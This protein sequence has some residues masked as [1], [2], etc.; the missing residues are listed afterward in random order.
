MHKRVPLLSLFNGLPH[1]SRLG[2]QVSIF[3]RCPSLMLESI[4]LT[5]SNP[6]LEMHFNYLWGA[7]KMV[8]AFIKAYPSSE[9]EL[10]TPLPLLKFPL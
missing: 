4:N 3:K 8:K 1:T 7:K 5:F 10:L 9:L 6:L 2:G